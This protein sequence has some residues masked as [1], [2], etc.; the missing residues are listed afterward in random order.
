M[1]Y[2]KTFPK[3]PYRSKGNKK[4]SHKGC[5][6]VCIYLKHPEKCYSYNEWV[7]LTKDDSYCVETPVEL[8]VSR[9]EDE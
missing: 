3:C 4:C 7:K 2:E 1:V 9:S 8:N 5:P 6:K